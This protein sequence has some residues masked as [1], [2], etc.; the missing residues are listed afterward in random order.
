[1][2][3]VD[4]HIHP[5]G[6]RDCDLETLARFGVEQVLVC[7]HDGAVPRRADGAASD[8]MAHFDALLSTQAA[9]IRRHGLRPLFALGISP[10][11]AP[12][13]GLEELLHRLP[14][15]LSHP[16]VVGIG[17]LGLQNRDAREQFVLRRQ[18]ELAVSL[19]RPVIVS[20]PTRPAVPGMRTLID[21]LRDSGIDPGRVLIENATPRGIAL[22]DECGYAV[23]LEASRGRLSARAIL[24][25]IQARGARRFVLTSHAGEGAADLLAVPSLVAS[26]IDGGLSDAIVSR[27]GW[28]NALRFLGRME[29]A[30]RAG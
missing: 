1:M 14:A 29:P 7:A 26:L 27:V 12:W 20:A 3:L 16:A 11:A 25:M 24:G 19:R 5:E 4:S 15:Y 23:A 2:R 13:H 22:A 9:R 10:A 30:R 18:L 28:E 17:S 8:W 21:W 6:L